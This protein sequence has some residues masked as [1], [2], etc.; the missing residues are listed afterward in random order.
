MPNPDNEGMSMTNPNPTG[1]TDLP[2]VKP[3]PPYWQGYYAMKHNAFAKN[4]FPLDSDESVEWEVGAHDWNEE[5]DH[6]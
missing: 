1:A 5:H 3:K 2:T 6:E 4:P